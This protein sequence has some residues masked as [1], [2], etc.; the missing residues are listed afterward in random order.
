MPPR[1]LNFKEIKEEERLLSEQFRIV[2]KNWVD[3]DGAASLME[4]LKTTA[5]ETKKADLILREGDMA[6]NKAER[7]VKANPEW[8]EYITEM[9]RLRKEANLLKMQLKYIEMRFHEWQSLEATGRAEMKM[10]GR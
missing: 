2:C 8:S 10:T 4:E 3:A 7:M 5:L 1:S 9:C 6:D